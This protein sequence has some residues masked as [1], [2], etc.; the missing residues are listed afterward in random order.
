MAFIS[1]RTARRQLESESDKVKQADIQ[2]LLEKQQAV[3]EKVKNSGKLD[4][5][6]TDIK[7]MFSLVR[8]YYNGRYRSIPWKSIAAIVGAL[9]YVLNPLDLIPDLI[10]SIGFVDDVGVVALCLKLVESDLHR[11]AAWKELQETN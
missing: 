5:F 1:E 2:R 8:D 3:E 7:L 4:R 11:Y 10:L 6:T 9:I